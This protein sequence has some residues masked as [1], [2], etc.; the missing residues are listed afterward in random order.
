MQ[1]YCWKRS[2]ANVRLPR[3]GEKV[4]GKRREGC[5]RNPREPQP[6]RWAEEQEMREEAE[7]LEV[8]TRRGGIRGGRWG[9]LGCG[10]SGA[11]EMQ[12]T[13]LEQQ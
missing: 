10:G 6:Q 7:Y 11:G 12:T 8:Y 2:Q 5:K 9:Q 3:S 4:R 13:I 1:I